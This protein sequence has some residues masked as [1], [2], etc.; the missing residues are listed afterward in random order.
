MLGRH[1]YRV[2]PLETGGWRVRKDGE[3]TAQGTRDT[4]DE[5]AAYAAQLAAADPPSKVIIE[6]IGGTIADERLFGADAGLDP[7]AEREETP[8]A[9][10]S[11]R[12]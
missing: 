3:V 12:R 5:A 4:R 1:I 9:P 10:G 6:D 11:S 2:S 8:S 7:E